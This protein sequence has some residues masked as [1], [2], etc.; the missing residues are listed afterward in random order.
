MKTVSD[1]VSTRGSATNFGF[2]DVLL[3]GLARDGGLFLPG[4]WPQF[5]PEDIRE[6]AGLPY[7]EAAL[8]IMLPFVRECISEDEF[9]T[10]LNDA[11]AGFAHRAVAPLVQIGPNDWVL[12]LFHGPTLAF[13]DFAMQV[14]ARLM[15]RTLKSRNARATII[16]A[17]SGDT[18]GAAIEAFRGRE[19]IDIFILHPEGRVS[20][21]QRCQMTTALEA[22]VHNIAL[23]GTFDDCQ[24]IVK[25]LFN[26][27]EFR[28]R[29]SLAGVNS[30]NW[31]R[32]MGQIVYYFT[33]AVS[34]GAP[35]RAVR[36][37]VPTGN[38][39][40]IYAGFAAKQMG[41]PIA[42]LV[43][44]TNIND[45]L[46]RVLETGNY[47]PQ[48]VVATQSP[49]MDIQVSSNFE[50]LLFTLCG[51]D[52]ERVKAL[53][54]ELRAQHQFTLSDQEFGE[55]KS[56]F[57]VYRVDETET[58]EIIR[59]LYQETGY[60]ADPHTAVGIGAA[61]KTPKDPSSPMIALATAHPAKFP[62]TVERAIGRELDQPEILSDKLS[63]Q[64][65]FTVLHNDYAAVA[66]FIE[67]RSRAVKEPLS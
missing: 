7:P 44:A 41:L 15:D 64:E 49:S 31:A 52:S 26:D 30:I 8:K 21:V 34:L 60:I 42:R 29:H 4:A 63:A 39:G 43:I 38:F 5:S 12:E 50:R 2:E 36:F 66:H 59:R 18:G 32:I 27:H 57:S 55:L 67:E 1:Y 28:D 54:D 56:L 35:D 6:L 3:T 47:Q 61:M 17:T 20:D 58:V 24:A 46:K 13:K 19:A 23:E 48:N 25:A 22:N 53:M 33:A 9:Q 16:G 10:L 40:D 65:R 14:L 11:Y 45:I 37:C 62:D 51:R